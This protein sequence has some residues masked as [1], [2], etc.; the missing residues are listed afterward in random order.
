[1]LWWYL[2]RSP[3]FYSDWLWPYCVS[4]IVAH[5]NKLLT[6]WRCMYIKTVFENFMNWGLKGGI[7]I[8]ADSGPPRYVLWCC[9]G[10]C[11]QPDTFIQIGSGHT[12]E[13]N[14]QSTAV[15]WCYLTSFLAQFLKQHIMLS[16][17]ELLPGTEWDLGLSK[18]S[19]LVFIYKNSDVQTRS[20][21]WPEPIWI[22]VSG[23]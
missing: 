19:W 2:S 21:V 15:W 14:N 1:M 7:S 18:R 8:Y 22:K 6:Q 23:W 16:F 10:I 9:G 12:V 17:D 13:V 3:H 4:K 20:T 11:H 5:H